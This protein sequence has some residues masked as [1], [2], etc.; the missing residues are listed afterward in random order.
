MEQIKKEAPLKV[1]FKIVARTHNENWPAKYAR[2]TVDFLVKEL[3]D[4]FTDELDGSLFTA[5]GTCSSGSSGAAAAAIA[6]RA[7]SVAASL[8]A[9]GHR[10]KTSNSSSINSSLLSSAALLLSS[11]AMV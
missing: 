9:A 8:A 10:S 7:A 1:A 6:S 5:S 11:A 3:Q 2:G 4:Y